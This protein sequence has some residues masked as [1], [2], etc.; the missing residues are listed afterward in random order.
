VYFYNGASISQMFLKRKLTLSLSVTNPFKRFMTQS[1]SMIDQNSMQNYE[2]KY[3]T[4]NARISL[5]YNFGKM[6][7][8][9]KKAKRGISNDDVKSGG[10]SN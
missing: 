6:N 8:E 10:S 4:R 7:M 2:Y 9:V 1:Y 5:S 3:E